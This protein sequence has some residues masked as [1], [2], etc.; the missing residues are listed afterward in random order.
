M[1]ATADVYPAQIASANNAKCWNWFNSGDQRRDH[2]EPSLIAGITRQVAQ[3][4]GVDGRRVY[5]AGMSAALTPVEMCALFMR[6]WLHMTRLELF[7]APLSLLVHLPEVHARLVELFE[8]PP[9]RRIVNLLRAGP[10]P[11]WVERYPPARIAPDEL[12]M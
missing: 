1:V 3:E 11:D 4:Y 5:I 9:G 2:G 8:L 12:L 6:E 10:L 7:G